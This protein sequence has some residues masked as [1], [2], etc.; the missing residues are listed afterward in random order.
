MYDPLVVDT[1]V[2]VHK[3]IGPDAATAQPT[4]Q[5]ISAIAKGIAAVQTTAAPPL[6]LEIRITQNDF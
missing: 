1:F 5:V 4:P 6:R 2:R 3:A